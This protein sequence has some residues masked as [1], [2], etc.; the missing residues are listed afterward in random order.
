MKAVRLSNKANA[1]LDEIIKSKNNYEVVSQNKSSVV[2]M[3]IEKEHK[4]EFKKSKFV[5]E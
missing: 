3:L 2:N 4:R 1:L 5:V